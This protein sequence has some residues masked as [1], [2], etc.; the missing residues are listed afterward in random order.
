MKTGNKTQVSKALFVL[1]ID[2]G[3]RME[4]GWSYLN[5]GALNLRQG[6]SKSSSLQRFKS[7]GV[8]G[9]A[10]RHRL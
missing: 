6:F 3:K 8:E 7:N 9:N 10:L 5:Y 1:G 4:G 2:F